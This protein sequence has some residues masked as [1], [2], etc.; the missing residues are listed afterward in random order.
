MPS[1]RSLFHKNRSQGSLLNTQESNDRRSYQ[2][3]PI[4]TPIHSPR[5]PSS[6]AVSPEARED[7][8]EYTFGQPSVYRPDEARYYYGVNPPTRSQSQRSPTAQDN[9]HQQPTIN[10]VGPAAGSASQAVDENPDSYYRQVPPAAPPKEDSK[11]RRFF[12]LG[13][14][15]ASKEQS[16]QSYNP[17]P[18]NRLGRSISVKR[19]DPQLTGETISPRQSQ[20]KWPSQSG[21]AKSAPQSAEVEEEDEDEDEDDGDLTPGRP[22]PNEVGP[23]IPEKDPLRSNLPPNSSQQEHLYGKLPAQG[24]V[25]SLPQRHPYERQGSATSSQWENTARSVQ[26]HQRAPQDAFQ[27]NTPYQPS[28]ASTIS[29]QISSSYH[30]SP[31]S[32]TSTSSHPLQ[33]RAPQE[34]LQQYRQ[35]LQR[36]RPPSQQSSYDPPSPLNTGIRSHDSHHERQG[37]NRSSLNAYTSSPM[38]PPPPPQQQGQGRRSDELAQPN[39]PGVIMR[40][41]SGYQPYTQTASGQNQQA[42]PPQYDARLSVNQQNQQFRGTPQPSP[43]PSQTTNEQGRS[44]PPPSRSRDDLASLDVNQIL[45]RHDELRKSYVLF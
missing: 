1:T 20:Q 5:F 45:A 4:D 9:S 44:T 6:S 26:Q 21:P 40:E 30:S 41:G 29:N 7:D 24:L 25:T 2:A 14:S 35:D 3:S 11:R 22:L 28:P 12:K 16:P 8:E 13:S 39:P 33:A 36:E 17:P 43:L 37:S 19:K 34:A 27:S 18:A 42:N 31:A 32:A 15:S 38:G 23:P 10:L